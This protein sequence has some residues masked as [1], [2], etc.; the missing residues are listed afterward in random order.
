[1]R[2][3]RTGVCLLVALGLTVGVNGQAG[4]PQAPLQ[5][6]ERQHLHGPIKVESLAAGRTRIEF[7]LNTPTWLA[8]GV[9]LEADTFTIRQEAGGGVLIESAGPARV[10]GFTLGQSV[11]T[12][13]VTLRDAPGSVLTWE[14]RFKLRILG[15]GTLEWACCPRKE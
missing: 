11:I 2:L 7:W 12:N 9:V 1:M 4:V 14:Q 6:S 5:A 3:A 13:A 8:K 10:T 15:D